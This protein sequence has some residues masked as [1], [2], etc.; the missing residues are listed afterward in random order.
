[1]FSRQ[2]VWRWLSSAAVV[3]VVVVACSLVEVYLHFRRASC[4]HHQS[5][6]IIATSANFYQTTWHN[7]PENSRLLKAINIVFKLRSISWS[8]SI[9]ICNSKVSLT[10]DD[11]RA[12]NHFIRCPSIQTKWN[13]SSL[14]A[15]L[16]FYVNQ[17]IFV[18][19]LTPCSHIVTIRMNCF[20]R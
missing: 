7:N 6:V 9:Q 19:H 20:R 10:T 5:D 4:F 17:S 15:Y 11:R 3:V 13:T 14:C 1:M 12:N 16:G 18:T 2:R 8:S